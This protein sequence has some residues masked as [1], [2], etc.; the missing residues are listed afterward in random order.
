ME[1]CE[2]NNFITIDLEKR[3]L[4]MRLP[5]E[6]CSC[7]VIFGADN[8]FYYL[9]II[10]MCLLE[11]KNAG[12]AG[13][14]INE[15]MDTIKIL[16]RYCYKKTKTDE[17]LIG[18]KIYKF[19]K[20]DFDKLNK[21]RRKVVD[22]KPKGS[23]KIIDNKLWKT[24]VMINKRNI[25]RFNCDDIG[26][27]PDNVTIAF[28]GIANS[29]KAWTEF[30]YA[31]A[32]KLENK[33]L[34]KTI[35]EAIENNVISDI[36]AHLSKGAGV[37]STG[38]NYYTPLQTAVLCS[39][40]G[41]VK[42][43]LDK[44][45]SPHF[46]PL[47][48]INDEL[49]Y[50]RF[51]FDME[52]E[53]ELSFDS[54]AV[55]FHGNNKEYYNKFTPL[56]VALSRNEKEIAE[57]LIK[58][59]SKR[60]NMEGYRS[61]SLIN[62]AAW[63][64]DLKSI[65]MLIENGYD[66][67]EVD[68]QGNNA[69]H[70][71]LKRATNKIK[72]KYK[73]G[74][75]EKITYFAKN[76]E[77]DL[78]QKN[79]PTCYYFDIGEFFDVT[80]ILTKDNKR[81]YKANEMFDKKLIRSSIVGKIGHEKAMITNSTIIHSEA[82]KKMIFTAFELLIE[83]GIN[84]NCMDKYGNTP[85]HLAALY[86]LDQVVELL[87]NAGADRDVQNI[88]KM[89][90]MH[91]AAMQSSLLSFQL[92]ADQRE[93]NVLSKD[94]IGFSP[95]HY[96]ILFSDNMKENEK[97]VELLDKKYDGISDTDTNGNT[98]LHLAIRN[99]SLG[100]ISYLI[101]NTDQLFVKNNND[102]DCY[103]LIE[104]K[105]GSYRAKRIKQKKLEFKDVNNYDFTIKENQKNCDYQM[106][107]YSMDRIHRSQ[108]IHGKILGKLGFRRYKIGLEAERRRKRVILWLIIVLATAL[109]AILAGPNLNFEEIIKQY[110]LLVN[111]LFKH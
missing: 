55:M 2:V 109:L 30:L 66:I 108:T 67:N 78:P 6:G 53:L 99:G 57:Y 17:K 87:I 101:N 72:V 73:L 34:T 86:G 48:K 75:N 70:V 52:N 23:A 5:S 102:I 16:D 12:F 105:Y 82:Y 104:N 51:V 91:Y 63:R 19:W 40:L 50:P 65:S 107:L 28:K 85:L 62:I 92:L 4:D 106:G 39:N 74:A 71:I 95:S 18:E 60:K 69:L 31:I 46:V 111:W 37:N 100:C 98:C 41:A 59:A 7:K 1:I 56:Q 49:K 26:V 29:D 33:T 13:I 21:N 8:Q 97:M 77:H 103:S 47:G 80:S 3:L 88:Y 45:A 27:P 89:T 42:Q 96:V 36:D 10:A 24:L 83:N 110:E 38:P 43:L 54:E 44:N 68:P 61:Q 94:L 93:Q 76:S 90:P 9:C 64:L 20:H 79:M 22:E 25:I 35:F 15:K 58:C 32:D 84:F 14:N 81:K 11:Y